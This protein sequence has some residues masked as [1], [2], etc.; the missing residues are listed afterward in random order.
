MRKRERMSRPYTLTDAAREQRKLAGQ[1]SSRKKAKAGRI[2]GRVSSDAKTA[3][4]RLNGRKGGRPKKKL[5]P[6]TP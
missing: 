4:A 3:A 2:G 1:A 5:A 6:N